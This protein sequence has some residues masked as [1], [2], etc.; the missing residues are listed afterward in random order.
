M[1]DLINWLS[2]FFS[3]FWQ[4][5]SNVLT[6]VIDVA[7][8]FMG[9]VIYCMLDGLFACVYVFFNALDLS[10]I[11]FDM[12]AEWS[13]VPDQLVWLINQCGIP[14]CV[15]VITGAMAIRLLLNIIPAA[16]TRI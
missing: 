6:D 7:A 10:T 3:N 16:F 11:A 12:A 13:N 5:L 15:A 9:Y 8:K 14:Q 2:D 4:L 1:Q